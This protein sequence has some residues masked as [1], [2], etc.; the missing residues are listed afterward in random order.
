MEKR[1]RNWSL[2]AESIY[3]NSLSHFSV[4]LIYGLVVLFKPNF[5]AQNNCSTVG[6]DIH[7]ARTMIM[8]SILYG[9]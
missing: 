3:P 9:T 7:I 2:F 4:P 6:Q 5:M 8:S 1:L